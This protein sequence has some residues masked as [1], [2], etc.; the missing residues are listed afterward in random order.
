MAARQTAPARVAAWGGM[1]RCTGC[2]LTLALGLALG[3]LSAAPAARA[4]QL[5]SQLLNQDIPPD[6]SQGRNISVLER[7]HPE[8]DALG[9][10]EGGFTVYPSI[11]TGFGYSDNIFGTRDNKVGDEYFAVAPQVSVNSNWSRNAV[12][13]TVGADLREFVSHS[14]ENE[15]GWH[16]AL[17][18]KYEID[19]TDYLEAGF[20]S[21]K[22]Y[23]E[24]DSGYYPTGAAAP[25]GY[26]DTGA[27]LRANHQTGRI[28]LILAGDYHTYN[29]DSVLAVGGGQLAQNFNNH[30]TWRVT[31]RGEYNLT[32]DTALFTEISHA[33]NTYTHTTLGQDLSGTEN[34]YLAGAN[35]DLTALI[36]GTV[37]L[38]YIQRDYDNP[39]F[40]AVSGL[41]TDV[42]LE[43]F[44]TTLMTVTGSV[45]REV[46]DSVDFNVGGFLNTQSQLRVDY[47]LLR[48]LLLNAEVTYEDD[49]FHGVSRDDHIL[50][51][52]AGAHYNFSRNI[53]VE[54]YGSYTDRSSFGQV[55]GPV[56]SE[57]K[58]ILTLYFKV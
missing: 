25:L 56:F 16:V 58:F 38:G 31:G 22:L 41:A 34:R 8:Y 33:D 28:H 53:G 9:V 19:N 52:G 13:A 49:N 57:T 1:H 44:P 24:Q 40:H 43:Y 39:A 30:D 37:G 4:Q 54:A 12:S 20:T 3:T 15:Q 6:Y 46:D 11:S 29:Y 18:G 27:F 10:P 32:P 26:V 55:L 50:T 35:F 47:E 17:N 51:Y 2:A 5:Q 42:K 45:K 7:P 48:N 21:H 36:R 14:S 23:E